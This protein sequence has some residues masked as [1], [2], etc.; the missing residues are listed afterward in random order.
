[1]SLNPSVVN[2]NAMDVDGDMGL[3]DLFSLPEEQQ[4]NI[5]VTATNFGNMV[6]AQAQAPLRQANVLQ[7]AADP[8][9]CLLI[10]PPPCESFG[11]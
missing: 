4:V 6:P 8:L 7:P 2:N 3:Q 10:Y 5:A 9:V 11:A 1:M